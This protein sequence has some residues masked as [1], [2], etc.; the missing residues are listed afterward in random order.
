MVEFG[1]VDAGGEFVVVGV[2]EVFDRVEVVYEEFEGAAGVEERAGGV[3]IDIQLGTTRGLRQGGERGVEEGEVGHVSLVGVSW[4]CV[5][6]CAGAFGVN[7]TR[8]G[9]CFVREDLNG[10]GNFH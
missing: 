9:I 2:G 1:G 7:G 6:E 8:V 10:R 4:K 5:C 3:G